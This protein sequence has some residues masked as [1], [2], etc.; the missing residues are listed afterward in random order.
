MSHTILAATIFL[1]LY[2]LLGA[3]DGLYLHL[4]RYRLHAEPSAR[5]EHLWH[6]ARAVLFPLTVALLFLA[7]TG[8]AL[9]W[10][11]VAVMA[12]DLALSVADV[13]EE[14]DSRRFMGGL[15]SGEY[16]LHGILIALHVAAV[17]L[18]LGSR[19]AAAW[20]LSAPLVMAQ[21]WPSLATIVATNLL[22]GA[23][24][25]AGVHV[26]LAVRPQWMPARG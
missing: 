11:G 22:P 24:L 19:P 13:L 25:V 7:P 1:T 9:L 4:W 15:P 5:R 18:L 14:G 26:A 20:S 3:V 12:S 6:T 17:A 23:I 8:G 21:P 10:L 2:A 16:A